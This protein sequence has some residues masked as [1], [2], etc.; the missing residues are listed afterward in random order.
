MLI[1]YRTIPV[2]CILPRA[3]AFRWWFAQI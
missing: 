1:S 3:R 2:T